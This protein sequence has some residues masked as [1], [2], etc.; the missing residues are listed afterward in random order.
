M[1]RQF[2][3]FFADKANVSMSSYKVD[4]KIQ[5]PVLVICGDIDSDNGS[6]KELSTILP[7]A[8][9]SIVPGDH[10]HAASTAEF[11]SAV[12]NFLKQNKY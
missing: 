3:S 5:Q 6:A 11:S 1:Q 9:F 8:T 10:N 4:A 12:L 7:H 2:D